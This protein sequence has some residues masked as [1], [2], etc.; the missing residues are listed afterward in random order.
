MKKP[1]V[2]DADIS[3][4]FDTIDHEH[5]LRAIGKVPGAS[6]IRQWLKA[7]YVD[8]GVFHE[9]D[10][11]TPQGGVISPLL[12]NI[13]LHGMEEALG[14]E[15]RRGRNTS[16]RALVRYADDFVVFAKSRE[17]AERVV[18]TLK[19]WLA[20]RG[21]QL[22]EEKTRIVHLTEG[23]DFLGFNV[24][25]YKVS[26]TRRGYKL[27]IKPSKDA[28]ARFRTKVRTEWLR[29]RGHS[30]NAALKT[31]VPIVRG[32]ANY[33]RTVVSKQTFAAL[34]H[35]M[36]RRAYRY[37]R[38]MHPRKPWKWL[39]DRYWG[40]F[41]VS[42]RTTWVFGDRHTGAFLPKMAWTKIERHVMVKGKHSP[43]DPTLVEYWA[44]RTRRGDQ[45]TLATLPYEKRVLVRRQGLVCPLCGERILNGEEIHTHHVRGRAAGDGLE[46]KIVVHLYCHQQVHH[47]Q[48]GTA[49]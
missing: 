18:S 15:Y 29:L 39:K 25:H 17:D 33:Y 35:W 20:T 38:F 7:G 21:L 23:F 10:A 48:K 36:H 11:G 42:R 14:I 32:W 19:E 28:V 9:T 47:Q 26:N 37:A 44:M 1:W 5:L 49:A 41:A 40:K 13:A 3:G 22:A 6:L 24:K 34:D 27:L 46:N 45:R 43:D 12:A 31:I 16:I 4:A 2:V 30:I 8:T